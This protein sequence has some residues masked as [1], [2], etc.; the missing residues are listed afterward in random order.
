M[1][2]IIVLCLTLLTLNL[3][4]CHGFAVPVP[5][6]EEKTEPVAEVESTTTAPV[7]DE[8][9]SVPSPEKEVPP[10][11][12]PEE[13][14]AASKPEEDS[15]AVQVSEEAVQVPE[16]EEVQPDTPSAQWVGL[17]K[18]TK[19]AAP[20]VDKTEDPP[21]MP[22]SPSH[23]FLDRLLAFEN[24]TLEDI[25][26]LKAII[27]QVREMSASDGGKKDGEVEERLA[28]MITHN[29]SA[30][31]MLAA[32]EELLDALST[33]VQ[34]AVMAKREAVLTGSNAQG[35]Q[36]SLKE[37][38]STFQEAHELMVGLIDSANEMLPADAGTPTDNV[39]KSDEPTPASLPYTS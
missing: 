4:L 16:S 36:Q 21:V 7:T 20:A 2:K 3:D 18:D 27:L 1:S 6:E 19:R 32:T 15:E 11:S 26:S 17:P 25:N 38:M 29:A 37:V 28:Y 13:V 23:K 31:S 33:H 35:P 34:L 8:P 24:K 14:Q 22:A 39:D 10:E 9:P 30:E 12:K 5:E